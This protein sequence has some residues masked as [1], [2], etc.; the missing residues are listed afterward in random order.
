[1]SR[2]GADEESGVGGSDKKIGPGGEGQVIEGGAYT[3]ISTEVNG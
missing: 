2:G 1:M 3:S